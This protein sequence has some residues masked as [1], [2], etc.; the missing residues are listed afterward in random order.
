[1]KFFVPLLL[2]LLIISCDCDEKGPNG[3]ACNST[4]PMNM[5]EILEPKEG[6]EVKV[7][8]IE[9]VLIP[10]MTFDHLGH[11]VGYGKGFYDKLLGKCKPDCKRIGLSLFEPVEKIDDIN[12]HD[13]R[14]QCCI[15]PIKVLNFEP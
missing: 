15:T 13:K 2:C 11:R 12:P 14:L 4:S 5:W 10:L 1:M 7:E 3:N 6:K 9:M 8:Q